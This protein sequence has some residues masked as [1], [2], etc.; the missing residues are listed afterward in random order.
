MLLPG[1]LTP[2]HKVGLFVSSK[3][4]VEIMVLLLELREGGGGGTGG[5]GMRN[6]NG[7]P[8]SLSVIENVRNKSETKSGCSNMILSF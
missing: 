8:F 7:P 5:T 4:E 1:W 2:T 3:R 6:N